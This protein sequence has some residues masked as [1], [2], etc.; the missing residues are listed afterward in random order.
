MDNYSTTEKLMNFFSVVIGVITSIVFAF[1][2]LVLFFAVGLIGWTD[3]GEYSSYMDTSTPIALII[4]VIVPCFT[5]GYVTA[6]NLNKK[7]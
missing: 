7:R 6:K 4:S 1:L 3:G 5:G 2:L